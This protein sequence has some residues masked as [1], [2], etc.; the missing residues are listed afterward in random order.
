MYYIYINKNFV[1]QV[2][3]QPRSYYDARSTNHQDP[4]HAFCENM[5]KCVLCHYCSKNLICLGPCDLAWELGPLCSV[6]FSAR[7]ATF[8][9]H[10]WVSFTM[11]SGT[12][13]TLCAVRRIIV[14]NKCLAERCASE[15]AAAGMSLKG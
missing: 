1:H 2:G 13:L 10:V 15:T 4:N 14:G 5:L 11:G 6:I 7:G 12:L 9:Q 8:P 3:D